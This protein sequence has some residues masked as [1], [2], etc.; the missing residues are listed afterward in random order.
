MSS[1]R[2]KILRNGSLL[3]K[4]VILKKESDSFEALLQKCTAKFAA[5][6]ASFVARRMFLED[7]SELEEAEEVLE[8]DTV[9]VSSGENFVPPGQAPAV[10]STQPSLE[11]TASS[12]ISSAGSASS[13]AAL[14]MTPDQRALAPPRPESASSVASSCVT[15]PATPSGS[16]APPPITTAASLA[17]TL[18]NS[19]AS[20]LPAAD[21]PLYHI[22]VLQAAPLVTRA[23]GD[24]KVRSLP[25]L[26]LAAERHT[27]TEAL[28]TP[29]KAISITF[30]T[31]T[32]SRLHTVDPL[33]P[34]LAPQRL[35]TGSLGVAWGRLRSPAAHEPGAPA[36]AAS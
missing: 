34:R 5:A 31:A 22:A 21:E 18:A 15:I 3:D 11:S 33:S 27:L 24:K 14:A 32:T 17:N 1:G 29:A 20:P 7:G 13:L 28:G 4:K 8:G 36:G 6:D 16:V 12:R 23:P 26:N 30:E 35:R 10:P 19:A 2:V 25:Q 9:V